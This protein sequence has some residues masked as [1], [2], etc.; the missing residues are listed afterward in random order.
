MD[1]SKYPTLSKIARGL[2]KPSLVFK[3]AA[4]LNVFTEE[5]VR[6]DIAVHGGTIVGVGSYDGIEE[7]DCTGK[8]AAPGFIDAHLHLESTLVMP[9]E[10][11]KTALACGTT[12][13][14]A[15]PHEAVN[16]A[17][18]NGLQF[19]LDQ[20]EHV[21]ANVYIMLPSCV[22]ATAIDDNGCDFTAARMER[23]RDHPRILGLGEVMDYPAVVNAAPGMMEKLALFPDKIKDGHAPG[24]D[25]KGMAAYAL[26]DIRTDHECTDF[27]YARMEAR[28]GMQVHIREGSAAR[29]LESIVS[30]IVKSGVDTGKFSFCTDDKHIDDIRREG[31]ISHNIK[32]SIALGLPPIKAYKMAAYNAAQCY[33]L[34]RLGGI[35]PGY[36]ADIV[37]L[38]DFEAVKIH[39]VYYKGRPIATYE[40][41]ARPCP[42]ALLTTVRFAPFAADA[43]ALPVR[44]EPMSA[45]EL[46][47]GQIVTRHIKERLPQQ[48]GVFVP[49]GVFAKAAVIERHHATGKIGV[50]AVR[51]FG[52]KTGAI[53][54]SM[55]HDCHNIIAIGQS[56]G[57]ILLAVNELKRVEGGYTIVENGAVKH[58][59]PLPVM[60]LMSDKPFDEVESVLNEMLRCA[61]DMGVP[62]G[63]DPFVTLSFI[64]L[65]VIPEIRITARGLYDA[66]KHAFIPQ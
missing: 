65:V 58:T 61:H 7:I 50:A 56:D 42:K 37:L 43:L 22:P 63:I 49:D 27:A 66:V 38:D 25:E 11:I 40:N 23:Y 28:N 54:T 2:E 6:S 55:A 51:G 12:T 41:A 18:E 59:L 15:D 64:A 35:A 26:A 39:S 1:Y 8:T 16:V 31:H 29:N 45:I 34:R 21:G 19:M 62:A 44:D 13:F 48:G 32:K 4:V 24:L 9:A 10:L 46:V 14:I 47:S 60:G 53:A 5:I 52:L 30:G 36:Q 3:N 57:D 33:G 20:T 17:G